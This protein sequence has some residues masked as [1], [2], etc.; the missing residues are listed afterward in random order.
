MGYIGQLSDNEWVDF[1]NSQGAVFGEDVSKIENGQQLLSSHN[2]LFKQLTSARRFAFPWKMEVLDVIC[3]PESNKS[4][5]RFSW[6]SKKV[7]LHVTSAFL[8]F[9]THDQIVEINE[10]YNQF[11]EITH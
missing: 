5:V 10:V 6:D 2:A 3:D 11:A 9:N 1:F 7:G 8:T 4:A